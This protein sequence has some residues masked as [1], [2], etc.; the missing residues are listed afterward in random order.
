LR[1]DLA[2]RGLV[3]SLKRIPDENRRPEAELLRSFERDRPLILGAL[4]DAVSS[5]LRNQD[6]IRLNAYPRMADFARWVS[7][8]EPALNWPTGT[9]LVS[10]QEQR[11]DTAAAGLEADEVTIRLLELLG[12]RGELRGTAT[13]LLGELN[14][15]VPETQRGRAWP[16]SARTLASRVRRAAPYLR[17][18]G[19]EIDERRAPRTRRRLFVFRQLPQNIVPIVPIRPDLANSRALDGDDTEQTR[20]QPCL[21]ASPLGALTDNDLTDGDEG[22]AAKPSLSDQC[23][24]GLE[25]RE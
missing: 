1:A 21:N 18:S 8:A 5:A 23:G 3:V 10:D 9:F 20:G 19:I 7:A 25:G 17:N 6:N 12:D 4:L 14:Q 13:E 22:D 11:Q 15:R 2:D 24:V 16:G